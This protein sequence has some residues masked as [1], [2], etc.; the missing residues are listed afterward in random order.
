MPPGAKVSA[1]ELGWGVSNVVVRVDVE[2]RP[3]VVLKQARGRL[4]TEAVWL[5]RL[6]RV[7]TEC[8]ALALLDG[9]L[10]EG[11]VPRVTY[12]DVP[13]FLFGMT[14]APDDSVVW[15]ERLLTGE[16]DPDVGR[17]AG[18]ALGVVH[19]STVGHPALDGRLADTGVF[20]E[21]R[22]DPFY[23]AAALARPEA[24]ADL[25]ALIASMADPRPRC[26]VLG[27]FSPKNILV[28]ARGLTLVDFETA[29]AG[30][31]AFDLGFFLSHLL[32]KSV[33]AVGTGCRQDVLGVIAAFVGAYRN[34]ASDPGVDHRA[35]GHAAACLLARVDGKS[36]VD[37]LDG[38]SRD[39]VRRFALDALARPRGLDALT[40]LAARDLHP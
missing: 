32:L 31:P 34:V 18:E 29:H 39:A 1:R 6:E 11:T 15:K 40:D 30:D 7:W 22:V 27:D 26:L 37:Y 16:A 19:A 3:P 36:P 20:D 5:S 9:V 25:N 4:R 17:W 14:C 12:T 38:R 13:N 10:P 35:S 28:H 33:H 23:R 24:A 8:D 2:G 21:L